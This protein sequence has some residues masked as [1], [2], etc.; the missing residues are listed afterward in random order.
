MPSLYSRLR[1]FVRPYFNAMTTMLMIA[2]S[3]S[4]HA[5]S[6]NTPC[7]P[8]GY[9]AHAA[10]VLKQY[11]PD[12]NQAIQLMVSCQ[13]MC[14][15]KLELRHLTILWAISWNNYWLWSVV[16][17]AIN[18]LTSRLFGLHHRFNR[19]PTD[20]MPTQNWMH[21]LRL[22]R[23]LTLQCILTQTNEQGCFRPLIISQHHNSLSHVILRQRLFSWAGE[24]PDNLYRLRQQVQGSSY[25]HID[26]RLLCLKR[27]V[28]LVSGIMNVVGNYVHGR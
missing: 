1:G 12:K 9:R 16:L 3:R 8:L 22:N 20:T 28:P 6:D 4:G 18:C 24:C 26:Y 15:M 7:I 17:I 11:V 13:T 2:L 21:Q 27:Q 23:K 25:S 19:R 5:P 10:E 14:Q